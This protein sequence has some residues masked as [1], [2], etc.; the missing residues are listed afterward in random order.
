MVIHVSCFDGTNEE[1]V[2]LAPGWLDGCADLYWRLFLDPRA[3]HGVAKTPSYFC[4]SETRSFGSSHSPVSTQH[5]V[6]GPFSRPGGNPRALIPA[7]DWK[8]ASVPPSAVWWPLTSPCHG[9]RE[10]KDCPSTLWAFW[11]GGIILPG[12]SS[13]SGN[14]VLFSFRLLLSKPILCFG[15]GWCGCPGHRWPLSSEALRWTH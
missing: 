12:V 14:V 5:F 11:T 2:T 7:L 13:D 10:G 3:A 6:D 8:A 4:M 15:P 1:H 9:L